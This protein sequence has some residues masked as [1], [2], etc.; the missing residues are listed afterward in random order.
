MNHI[1]QISANRKRGPRISI[2]QVHIP[3][4]APEY[5][6]GLAGSSRKGPSGGLSHVGGGIPLRF[7]IAGGLLQPFPLLIDFQG[8]LA[9]LFQ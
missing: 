7:G 6:S 3:A 1:S 8:P 5:G 4:M 9:R 2:S